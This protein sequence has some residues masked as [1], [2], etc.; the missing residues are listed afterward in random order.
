MSRVHGLIN[1]A[2]TIAGD[3]HRSKT[4]KDVFDK[5]PQTPTT[6]E[7]VEKYKK[8]RLRLE[9][10][11]TF[12]GFPV[13]RVVGQSLEKL[14]LVQSAFAT[15]VDDFSVRSQ[16]LMP[17]SE[18]AAF[19]AALK[20]LEPVYDALVWTPSLPKLTRV[21]DQLVTLAKAKDLN[22]LFGRAAAFYR[23]QWPEGVPIT[24]A[25]YP[26]PGALGHSSAE[27][28]NG[29][30]SLGVL[31]DREVG[32]N[33]LGVLFHELCHSLYEAQAAEF[34][35]EWEKYFRASS[36]ESAESAYVL[37]NEALAT[38][39]GNG[40]AQEKVASLR[41]GSWYGDPYIDVFA[42]E[43]YPSVK[44]Y[45]EASKPLDQ[46]F[47]SKAIAV[48]EHAVPGAALN[49][50]FRLKKTLLVVEGKI[51]GPRRELQKQFTVSSLKSL[52][53]IGSSLDE[54]KRSRA[55][56]IVVVGRD[57]LSELAHVERIVSGLRVPWAAFRG[58]P[59]PVVYSVLQGHRPILLIR[60]D[61]EKEMAEAFSRIGK[62]R[63]LEKKA[64]FLLPS[65]AK[66]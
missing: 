65:T 22:A 45:V 59:G 57:S 9:T 8:A 32:G 41:V 26:V 62:A 1:F 63:R 3:P 17:P 11:W 42:H 6:I 34:Q 38:A 12:P 43:L 29:L 49:L 2:E 37:I 64:S 46:A 33:E 50:E 35:A 24:I 18:H 15:D 25:L 4:L 28:M 48:L 5:S 56:L 66:T 54:I 7:A 16:G 55:S 21:R 39:L 52:S 10:G 61:G 23:A 19:I 27:S 53:T 14:L 47:A 30:Q 44:A 60:A 31:I 13:D 51:D 20:G 36:S 40:W 58:R